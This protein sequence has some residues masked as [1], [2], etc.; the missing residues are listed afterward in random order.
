MS[1]AEVATWKCDAI[2][3]PQHE[4]H[5]SDIPMAVKPFLCIAPSEKKLVKQGVKTIW[6]TVLTIRRRTACTTLE[7]FG[8]KGSGHRRYIRP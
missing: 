8:S 7:P 4:A 6:Y 3:A 1:G 5:F 2:D